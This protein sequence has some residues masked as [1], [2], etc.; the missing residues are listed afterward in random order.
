MHSMNKFVN[1]RL[2]Y[3]DE[4]RN[5]IRSDRSR[6]EKEINE[7]FDEIFKEFRILKAKKIQELNDIYVVH[8]E[9]M[10]RNEAA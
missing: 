9:Y 6:S 1:Q 4:C 5:K 10:K 3:L 7:Y 2:K 8:D